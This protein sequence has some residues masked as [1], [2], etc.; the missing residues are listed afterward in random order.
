M[1][2]QLH[3]EPQYSPCKWFTICISLSGVGLC[4]V[5]AGAFLVDDV[6]HKYSIL[7]KHGGKDDDGGSS[8]I[9]SF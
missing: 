5:V 7:D 3:H 4:Q 6:T 2:Y 1:R 8:F 9:P